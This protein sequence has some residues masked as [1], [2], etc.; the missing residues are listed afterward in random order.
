MLNTR[1]TYVLIRVIPMG[2][3]LG[4]AL[5]MTKHKLYYI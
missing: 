4:K 5:G 1:D 2:L 3:L